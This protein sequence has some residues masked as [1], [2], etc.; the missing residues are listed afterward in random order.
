MGL[1]SR[2]LMVFRI[3]GAAILDR[4]EDP[5]QTLDYAYSQQQELLR[6][7]RQGLV[8]VATAKSQLQAQMERL[9]ARIPQTEEL[10]RRALAA[11]REDLARLALSRKQTALA[12]LAGL[13]TQVAQTDQ[14]ER[15]LA[16]AHHQLSA[17]IEEFRT[18]RAALQV[19]YTAAEAQVRVNEALS[20]VSDEF[21]ELGTA[22]GRAEEKMERMQARAYAID[23]LI[24]S[25]SLALPGG[26]GDLVEGELRRIAGEQAVDEDLAVLRAQLAAPEAPPALGSGS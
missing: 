5:R 14:E 16:L 22:L 26:G 23:A 6:K 21:A 4:H 18:R 19:R 2:M 11:G 20:G 9:G 17:R 15:R 12:E 1:W 24:T 3:K 8:E 7:V 13:E 25:G 10:A